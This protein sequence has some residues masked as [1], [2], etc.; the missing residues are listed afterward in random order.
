MR[1]TVCLAACALNCLTILGAEPTPA[2]RA[3]TGGATQPSDSTVAPTAA[4]AAGHYA[5]VHGLKMYYEIH[6]KG[7]ALLLLHPGMGAI[8]AWPAAIEYFSKAYQVIAPEQMGHGRTADIPSRMMNYHDMAEDTVELLNQ[9]RIESVYVVGF[10]DGGIVGLDLAINHPQLVKKL[11]VSGANRSPDIPAK[12][13]EDPI[14]PPPELMKFIRDLY[15]RLS[16]DGPDHFPVVFARVQQMQRTQPN[17][18]KAQLA[19]ITSSALI[20]AGDHDLVTPEY[21]IEMWR[22]IP[23]AQ[24]WIAPNSDHGLPIERSELFNQTVDRFFKEESSKQP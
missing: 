3:K 6:G 4:T 2:A 14:Q 24:L 23:G 15:G 9:L 16:P 12:P 19:A 5:T 11:A 18:S 10:S 8:P 20:I 21:T 1:L 13:G 7:P 17:F 22:D